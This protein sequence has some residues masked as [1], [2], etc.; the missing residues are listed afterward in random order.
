MYGI[1]TDEARAQEGSDP[2]LGIDALQSTLFGYADRYMSV[3]AQATNDAELRLSSNPEARSLLHDTKLAAAEAVLSIA[4]G[5]NSE[6]AL[7]DMVSFAML[8]HRVWQDAWAGD[9]CW[10]P[11]AIRS[12]IEWPSWRRRSGALRRSI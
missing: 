6:V 12:W 2:A 11:S 5:P 7:L 10:V 9:T 8:H 4:T 3:I 1:A